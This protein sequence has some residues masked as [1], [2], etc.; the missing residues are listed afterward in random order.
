MPQLLWIMWVVFV[1]WIILYEGMQSI[2]YLS[3]VIILL[4]NVLIQLF[5]VPCF[6]MSYIH[7]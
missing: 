3:G 5:D 6:L 4:C 7:L 2:E 1:N